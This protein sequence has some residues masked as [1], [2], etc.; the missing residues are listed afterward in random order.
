[1]KA[2][3]LRLKAECITSSKPSLTIPA[4]LPR[5]VFNIEWTKIRLAQCFLRDQI[6][7]PI[8]ITKTPLD[9]DSLQP[10]MKRPLI[11]AGHRNLIYLSKSLLADMWDRP[12]NGWGL[13]QYLSAWQLP[14]RYAKPERSVLCGNVLALKVKSFIVDRNTY[15]FIYGIEVVS[16]AQKRCLSTN[17]LLP[18]K[19][20]LVSDLLKG[21][22][23]RVFLLLSDE[24]VIGSRSK[25]QH[26]SGKE[27]PLHRQRSP[28]KSIG[29]LAVSL[30]LAY[31]SIGPLSDS[32]N[33]RLWPWLSMLLCG[34]LIGAY[35]VF[36]FLVWAEELYK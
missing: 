2:Y 22:F 19:N 24:S 34:G 4:M 36:S 17:D 5:S 16:K 25:G 15:R 9:S 10:I 35:G 12:S 7:E 32:V 14:P 6:S 29:A 1:M 21:P 20:G 28:L 11:L 26:S 18:R 8:V 31:F 27:A 23:H 30:I 33:R 3:A 13:P